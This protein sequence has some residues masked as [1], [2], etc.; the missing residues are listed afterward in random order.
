MV[1]V[2]IINQI[3]QHPTISKMS[4]IEIETILKE[5]NVQ[6]HGLIK[7]MYDAMK[8]LSI[9]YSYTVPYIDIMHYENH[10]AKTV[11][12]KVLHKKFTKQDKSSISELEESKEEPA[13]VY[14]NTIV[15]NSD[16]EDEDIQTALEESVRGLVYSVK[17]TLDLFNSLKY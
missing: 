3:H 17:S 10:S 4:H 12:Y 8:T 2:D 15:P 13:R 11:F 9:T 1:A 16:D 14:L 6:I 7:M 5:L